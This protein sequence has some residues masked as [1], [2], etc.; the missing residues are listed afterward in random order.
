MVDFCDNTIR[1]KKL[2]KWKKRI[3]KYAY[4]GDRDTAPRHLRLELVDFQHSTWETLVV[5][6]RS[7]P[8][9]GESVLLS[10]V[11]SLE[12]RIEAS[13]R[14]WLR[15][16]PLTEPYDLPQTQELTLSALR[17][18]SDSRPEEPAR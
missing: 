11:V 13:Y 16:V 17:L 9:I 3:E 15:W 18:Q 5:R 2:G 1:R 4:F 8:R 10:N 7:R 12:T 6:R 14:R